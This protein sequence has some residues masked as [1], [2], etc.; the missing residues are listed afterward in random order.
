MT[1]IAMVYDRSETDEMG[2]KLTAQELGIDLE[3]LPF[4]KVAVGVGNSGISY[5]SIGRDYT[6]MFKKVKVVLNRAQSKNRRIFAAAILEALD[7]EVLNSLNI[8]LI[9]QSKIRTLLTFF[10]KDIMI[11]KTVYVPCNT[12]EVQVSGGVLD[13]TDAISEMIVQQLG[14]GKLV[15]KPDAGTHGS[16]VML[17]EGQEA[18]RGMLGGV[19]PSV[20]NPSGVLAQEYIPKWF[21]DLRILVEKEKGRPGFCYPNALVRGGFKEFRTNTFLGNMVFRVRL[22][23]AVQREAVRCAEA[24]GAGAEAWVLALD[25]MPYI[26][27]ERVLGDEEVKSYFKALEGPFSEVKNV[28]QDPA[29]KRDFVTYTKNIDEAYAKYMSTEAYAKIQAVIEETLER[30][31]DSVLFHEGNAC[32]EY[33]EQTRIVGGINVAESLLRCAMSLIDA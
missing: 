23:D 9:C 31:Q 12:Q 14:K 11:P 21:Y 33:Y 25:A 13:N 30:K 32:P 8:E 4:Y 29:K 3:Y 15:I 26:G 19:T 2:I 20:I 24:I 5:R 6:G 1:D 16:G 22:P 27:E 10:K 7:K 18:L 17:A 28:K